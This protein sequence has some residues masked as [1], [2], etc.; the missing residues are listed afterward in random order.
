MTRRI[1]Y[2]GPQGTFSEEAATRRIRS[3]GS[4]VPCPNL[5]AVF[6]GLAG[7]QL[8]EGVIPVENSIE[9]GVGAALDLLAASDN[10]AVTGEIFLPVDQALL[11]L[12]QTEISAI[13][14]VLSHPQALAQCRS[15]LNSVLAGAGT[16]E[17]SSTAEAARLVAASDGTRAAVGPAR[18]ATMYGLKVLATGIND[19]RENVTRFL[20]LSREAGTT[21]S[22][23]T[24]TSI[25]IWISDRPGALHDIL[26]EFTM[27]GLNLTRIESRPAKKRLGDYLFFIDFFGHRENPAVTRAL[28]NVSRLSLQ[29]KVL[30]SYPAAGSEGSIAPAGATRTLDDLRADIDVVDDLLVDLLARRAVLADLVGSLKQASRQIRDPK[31]EEQLLARVRK[32]AADRGVDPA[33]VEEVYRLLIGYSVRRQ[34]KILGNSVG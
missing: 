12:P 30:G 16:V 7:G 27:A 33:M 22:A 19:C 8:E 9:G 13:K 18:A 4:T 34:E 10:L 24:K 1:G 2:L 29:L 17:T 32:L 21:G 25:V 31:R 20:V 15:Y 23:Y 3:G 11:A 26:R 5:E 6:G 14:Q 28:A